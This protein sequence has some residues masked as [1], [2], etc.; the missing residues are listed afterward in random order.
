MSLNT[1]YK[2]TVFGYCCWNEMV[3]KWVWIKKV[4]HK[5]VWIVYDDCM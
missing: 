4:I 1:K 3:K 5:T 2:A